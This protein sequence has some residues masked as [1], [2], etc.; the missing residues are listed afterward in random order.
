MKKK[1]GTA[2]KVILA[3]LI[4][5]VVCFGIYTCVP[6]VRQNINS[7]LHITENTEGTLQR[8]NSVTNIT[9]DES[10][11]ILSF[12]E[13][14]NAEGYKIIMSSTSYLG[15][16]KYE[17]S[18]NSFEIEM[19]SECETGD[20]LNFSITALG[21]YVTTRNSE[22]STYQYIL[23]H[24]SE[25]K[26]EKLETSFYTYLKAYLEGDLGGVTIEDIDAISYNNNVFVIKGNA[27]DHYSNEFIYTVQATLNDFDVTSF[28]KIDNYQSLIVAF[29]FFLALVLLLYGMLLIT[30]DISKDYISSSDEECN[31]LGYDSGNY[32]GDNLICYNKC[33]ENIYNVT[34][35]G[36]IIQ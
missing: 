31:K 6:P 12:D 7:V 33:E 16:Y 25:D 30:K 18:T 14:E 13:V 5:G 9:F 2:F 28:E 20:D 11:K 10:T 3:V 24:T 17:T 35:R 27:L 23:Q 19:P 22:A 29:I 21:D 36:K 8:L 15:V 4:V 34:T 26:Y 32:N 1:K